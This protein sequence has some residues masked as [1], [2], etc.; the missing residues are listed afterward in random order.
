MSRV[1]LL[2]K[3]HK[4]IFVPRTGYSSLF[5]SY[6][7][8]LAQLTRCESDLARDSL[9]KGI[10]VFYECNFIELTLHSVILFMGGRKSNCADFLKD[11][12]DAFQ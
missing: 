2:L 1:Y 5:S 10:V 7:H 12:I 11:M 9:L 4:A 8:T 6:E 3:K